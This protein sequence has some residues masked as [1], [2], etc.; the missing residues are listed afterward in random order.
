VHLQ[1]PACPRRP[2][3]NFSPSSDLLYSLRALLSSVPLDTQSPSLHE[4]TLT[5]PSKPLSGIDNLSVLPREDSR[6]PVKQLGAPVSSRAPPLRENEENDVRPET[7]P[8]FFSSGP[9]GTPSVF[10]QILAPINLLTRRVCCSLPYLP[11]THSQSISTSRFLRDIACP[12]SISP[13]GSGP[14]S[15]LSRAAF[16]YTERARVN[17]ITILSAKAALNATTLNSMTEINF[18]FPLRSQLAML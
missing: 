11:H 8:R 12:C 17:L 10:F 16:S 3:K 13:A 5:I 14:L 15:G 18:C 2:S 7:P 6:T 4:R 1:G 9:L